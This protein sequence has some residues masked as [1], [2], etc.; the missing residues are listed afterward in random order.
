MPLGL[1]KEPKVTDALTNP[2]ASTKVV[3]TPPGVIFRMA[4]VISDRLLKINFIQDAVNNI[5]HSGGC[6]RLAGPECYFFVPFCQIFFCVLSN[7]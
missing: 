1:D 2:V 3:T 6:R 5:L 4:M 7:G